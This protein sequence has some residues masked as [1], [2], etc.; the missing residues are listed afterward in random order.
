MHDL[1]SML[2]MQQSHAPPKSGEELEVLGKCAAKKYIDGASKSLNDAVVETIKSAGLS[3]EQVRRVVEFTNTDAFLTEHKKEGSSRYV[4][5]H[6]GPADPGEILRDLNDGGGGTVF[7]RGADY[8]MPPPVTKTAADVSYAEEMAR[9]ESAGRRTGGPIGALAGGAIVALKR[10]GGA[11]KKLIGALGGA[12]GGAVS[13]SALGGHLGRNAGAANASDKEEA[14]KTAAAAGYGP[15]MGDIAADMA[16]KASRRH[17]M[18]AYQ[19]YDP[20]GQEQAKRQVAMLQSM[21]HKGVKVGSAIPL[22]DEDPEETALK[23][24]F[25]V[26]EEE[27]PHADPMAPAI[28]LKDKL[29][30]MADHLTSELTE[31]EGAFQDSLD[32]VYS[33]VK[34][35]SLEGVPLGQV[36]AAWQEVVPD[37][38]YVKVAFAHISPRLVEDGVFEGV[39][40]VGGSLEKVAHVGHVNPK[41][42]LVG[43]MAVMCMTL[44]KLAQARTAHDE[45]TQERERL[46]G[47]IQKTS[48]IMDA[49]GRGAKRISDSGGIV[50]KVTGAFRSAGETAGKGTKYVGELLGGTG[51]R[52]AQT[53]AN[54]VEKAITYTPHAAATVG[55]LLALQEARETARYSPGFQTAK[56]FA[57]SRIPYTHQNMV[58]QHQL[59]MESQY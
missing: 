18:P 20:F 50:P 16:S 12:L 35:A 42:P 6:G 25:A 52:G 9:G 38:A 59:A 47:F 53:A 43:S 49:I 24:A 4:D 40:A 27:L 17:Q 5:F 55:G 13:G 26:Q 21:G 2:L 34:H 28:Q 7:D 8:T 29:A 45:L 54:A 44:D 30:G 56:N 39:D 14:E 1:P 33:H 57:M 31:L 15:T 37:P 46:E 41:H 58:R 48:G 11:K 10:K 51:S 23:E 22:L 32:D 3:P 19:G 36:L